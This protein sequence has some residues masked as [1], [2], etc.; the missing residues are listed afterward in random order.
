LRELD[1]Y[2]A[3]LLARNVRRAVRDLEESLAV[4]PVVRE[5]RADPTVRGARVDNQRAR[6]TAHVDVDGV[7]YL[8]HA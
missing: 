4:R 6:H 5:E 7:L 8:C 3:F 2:R 1:E